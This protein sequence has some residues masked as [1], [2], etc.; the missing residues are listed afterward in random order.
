[1]H[2]KDLT[3]MD[4][5]SYLQ[6]DRRII[7]ITGATEQHAYLSLFTDI[8]IP[9][10][11]A[12]AVARREKILVAPPVNFGISQMFTEFPGTISLSEHTYGLLLTEIVEGLMYQGFTRFL[13]INGHGGNHQPQ[14]IDDLELE[15]MIRVIWF[16]WWRS[17]AVRDFE[18]QRGLR[19]EHA[20]WGENF[21][22]SRVGPLPQEPKPYIDSSEVEAQPTVRSTLGDGSFGGPYS[23]EDKYMF[24][25]FDA[26]VEEAATHAR[27]L[28]E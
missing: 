8:L 20:N 4:V 25:L 3:W 2:F 14:S 5:E 26:V 19:L 12:D 9:E 10:K 23:I 15:G 17:E 1:M 28:L 21:P 18:Q 6:R 7:L 16:D 22:F 11:I 24:Q 13:I 27:S